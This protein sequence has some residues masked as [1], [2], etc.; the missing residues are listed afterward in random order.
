ML[1]LMFLVASAL[2]ALASLLFVARLAGRKGPAALLSAVTLGAAALLHAAHDFTRWRALGVAPF[3]GIRESLSTLSLLVVVG[4]F[5]AW[6]VQR[7]LDVVGAFVTPLAFAMFL[8]SRGSPGHASD[9]LHAGALLAL[10]VG[11]I[12]L[13]TAAFS[14]AFG[15]SLAYLLQE[16]Q[17]KQKRLA[18]LFQ[19]LPPLEV[20][21]DVGFRCVVVGL[22]ALT[23]GIIT[24]LYVGARATVTTVAAWQRYVG[25]G[26]WALFAAVLLLRFAAGWRG[27]RAAIGTILGYTG[28]LVALAG[29][30][31]RPGA[32]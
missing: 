7:K 14:L 20:L 9:P 3:D 24:G 25:V 4:F 30:Y 19:R 11:S 16:R 23:L 21:D 5:A 8:A 6:R 17:V 29:Y 12:L 26:A 18:G 13:A 2:Y 27:R 32:V 28:A 1:D 22:P 31:L 10:H 15:T